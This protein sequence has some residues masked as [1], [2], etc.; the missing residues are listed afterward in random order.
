V[1]L[2]NP[3]AGLDLPLKV[4]AYED[5]AGKVWLV[6]PQPAILQKRYRLKGA[7]QDANFKAIAGALERL[8]SSAATK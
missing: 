3:R 6:Y 1:M 5:G 2:G 7:E 4:L 8:T